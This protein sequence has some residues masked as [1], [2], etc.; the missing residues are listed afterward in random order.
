MQ[1]LSH[2]LA[3]TLVVA[4]IA[5]TSAVALA[6]TTPPASSAP[7]T[8]TTTPEATAAPAAPEATATDKPAKKNTKPVRKMT[9]RQEIE[10]SIERGTVPARFRSS[11]PKE[12]QRYIPFEKR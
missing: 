3:V 9:R 8:T 10:R 6:Q 5:G 2:L 12:Y 4:L 11:V 1:K 7:A